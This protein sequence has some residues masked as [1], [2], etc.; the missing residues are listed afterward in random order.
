MDST[1][2]SSASSLPQKN[3]I[4]ALLHSHIDLA[5]KRLKLIT[6]RLLAAST[7]LEE[8]FR[9]LNRLYYKGKNQHRLSLFWRHVEEMRRFCLRINSLDLAGSVNRLRHMFYNSKSYNNPN[10]LKASWTH[11]PRVQDL[12][13]TIRNFDPT[14]QLLLKANGRLTNAYLSFKQAMQTGAFL[15]LIL[16]L[17]AISCR[18][19]AL[20]Q[21]ILEVQEEL[22]AAV[23]ELCS[24][25]EHPSPVSALPDQPN[26][27]T[28]HNPVPSIVESSLQQG[29]HSPG[30]TKRLVNKSEQQPEHDYELK[31]Q[32]VGLEPTADELSLKP[33]KHTNIAIKKGP[34]KKKGPVDEID[35]IFGF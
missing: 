20:F 4:D 1:S 9:V 2:R 13:M 35:A 18:L 11:V 17:S 3:S 10:V 30:A 5:L 24:S 19:H 22:S 25:L 15:Q 6:R 34:K 14:H 31:Q 32:S 23:T 7:A 28:P 29:R 33:A 16:T 26:F 21:V 27:D 12:K 8:E